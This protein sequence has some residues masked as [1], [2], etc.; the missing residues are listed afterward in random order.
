[1]TLDQLLT[2][3]HSMIEG[4]KTAYVHMKTLEIAHAVI[5]MLG[6]SQLC[7]IEELVIVQDP[8]DEAPHVFVNSVGGEWT[9]SEC[10]AYA[11]MLLRAADACDAEAKVSK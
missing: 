3:A 6:E 10:R 2:W 7:G 9:P 5:N 4:N 8:H 1:M 11:A